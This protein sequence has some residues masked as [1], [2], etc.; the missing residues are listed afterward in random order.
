M[1]V[2]HLEWTTTKN[3]SIKSHE[4]TLLSFAL[5]IHSPF[6][7]RSQIDFV[8]FSI[9][10]FGE[11]CVT[12]KRIIFCLHKILDFV[13]MGVGTWI[14]IKRSHEE[15]MCGEHEQRLLF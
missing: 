11:T 15:A 6:I 10:R 12:S 4:I 1:Y 5:L 3:M 9:G 8:G 13:F 2:T 14:P 7:Q